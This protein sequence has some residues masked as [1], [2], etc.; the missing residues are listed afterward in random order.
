[1]VG[2]GVADLVVRLRHDVAHEGWGAEAG[3]LDFF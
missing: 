3:E 1:V 2:L